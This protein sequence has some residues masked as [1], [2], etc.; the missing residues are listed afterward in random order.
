MDLGNDKDDMHVLC[1]FTPYRY[2]NDVQ[3]HVQ[4]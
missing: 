4:N 2:G 1:I 3:M